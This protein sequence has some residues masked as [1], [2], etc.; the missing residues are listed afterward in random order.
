MHAC[1]VL[2]GSILAEA[3]WQNPETTQLIAIR[4]CSDNGFKAFFSSETR[5]QFIIHYPTILGESRAEGLGLR[6]NAS[7]KSKHMNILAIQAGHDATATVFRS[8][9][10]SGHVHG[11]RV[12]KLK[13]QYGIDKSTINQ[14]ITASGLNTCEIDIVLIT[15]TQCMPAV[16]WDNSYFSF[17]SAELLPKEGIITDNPW[18]SSGDIVDPIVNCIPPQNI[19][20]GYVAELFNGRNKSISK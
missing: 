5:N 8:G 12:N 14:A 7:S 11:E 17:K 4:T 20:G 6:H 13:H 10:L 16:C 9:T 1:E 18:W 15:F 19:S 3:L 2:R